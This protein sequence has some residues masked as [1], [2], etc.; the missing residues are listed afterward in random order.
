[1]A[2]VIGEPFGDV[3]ITLRGEGNRATDL[4]DHVRHRFTHAGD[5]LIELGQ[6]LGAFAI[7]LTDMQVKHSGA[8]V[9]AINRH[10]HLL[11]HGDRDVFREVRRHPLRSVGSNG[12]DELLLIFR[13]QG[14]VEKVHA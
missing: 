6:S 2:G 10:L 4:N 3:A 5:Q 14:S 9:I 11:C 7:E 8:G 13:V 12:D 1:M